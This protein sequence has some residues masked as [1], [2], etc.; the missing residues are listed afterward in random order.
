MADWIKCS[1]RMPEILDNCWRTSSPVNIMCDIGVIPAYYGYVW[2]EG[3]KYFG[4]LESL[5]Y[6]VNDGSKP[7]ENEAGLILNV[8]HW[9][10]L[11]EPP[12]E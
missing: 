10:P 7:D 3:G 2:Y 9:Q 6:G 1:E 11:P 12:Q 5:K 8:T 4:F